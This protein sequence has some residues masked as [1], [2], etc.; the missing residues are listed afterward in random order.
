[1][2]HKL[3]SAQPRARASDSSGWNRIFPERDNLSG[4]D[5]TATQGCLRQRVR[6]I[7]LPDSIPAKGANFCKQTFAS[8]AS[9]RREQEK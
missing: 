4:W 5:S 6:K 2:L 9:H 1:M 3:S 8:F 7:D